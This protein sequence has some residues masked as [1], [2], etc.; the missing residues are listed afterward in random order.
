[1]ALLNKIRSAT[2]IEALVATVLIVVVFVIASLILNNLLLN[3]F[4]KNTHA[5]ENRLF[6]LGYNAEN[7]LMKFPYAEEFKNWDIKMEKEQIKEQVW[8]K[9]TAVNK[10]NK[11]EIIKYRLYAK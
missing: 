5:V 3:S 9:S 10:L 4:S 2:L 1:M 6:E 8:L 7:D 11:K